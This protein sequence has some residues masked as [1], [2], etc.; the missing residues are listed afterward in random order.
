MYCVLLW[1]LTKMSFEY[2]HLIVRIWF[3][4]SIALFLPNW[5]IYKIIWEQIYFDNQKI[6]V[7][8]I[9]P[10][11]HLWRST[12]YIP[13]KRTYKN[14]R[15]F[16]SNE[17]SHVTKWIVS[18][19]VKSLLEFQVELSNNWKCNS[20]FY[21]CEHNEMNNI[22]L[23]QEFWK[24]FCKKLCKKM[25]SYFQSNSIKNSLKCPQVK[26]ATHCLTELFPIYQNKH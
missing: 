4:N 11:W 17:E 2:I 24:E 26:S 19:I 14:T 6:K 5:D 10:F 20:W 9:L 3:P 7:L 16:I 25:E 8:V 15:T 22:K 23:T 18:N 1:K 21:F 12:R 13:V